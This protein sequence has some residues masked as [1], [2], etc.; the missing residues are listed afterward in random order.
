MAPYYR[1]KVETGDFRQKDGTV[2]NRGEELTCIEELDKLFPN[3]FT[4]LAD[5]PDPETTELKAF[6]FDWRAKRRGSRYELVQK[7]RE[8]VLNDTLL[9]K[10]GAANFLGHDWTECWGAMRLWE[11]QTVFIVGGGHSL[12]GFDFSPI[13][14]ARVIGV[15]DAYTYGD[16]V[17]V[18]YFGDWHWLVHHQDSLREW[19]NMKI[20]N[21]EECLGLPGVFTMERKGRGFNL[22]TQL[23]W[24]LNSGTTAIG[25]AAMLGAET[26]VLLGFDMKLGPEGESNWHPNNLNTSTDRT[27]K[28][29][30]HQTELLALDLGKSFPDVQVIN[31]GPDSDLEV[32]PKM[33]LEEVLNG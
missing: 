8:S 19:P 31:A 33:T 30:V 23:P 6:S 29:F 28:G 2:F 25:L 26:I 12:K 18:C 27:Y 10:A 5:I 24:Y 15:N 21:R 4:R 32:F 1:F 14:D 9:T 13:H 22:P 7:E 3:A 11:G 17:D 16:W 20:T